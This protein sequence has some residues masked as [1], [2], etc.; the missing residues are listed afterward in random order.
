MPSCGRA[1]SYRVRTSVGMPATAAI[2]SPSSDLELCIDVGDGDRQGLGRRLH[3][4]HAA[5]ARRRG[6]RAT[7]ASSVDSSSI[8][9]S[10]RMS[11]SS[12]CS[13]NVAISCINASASRG[14]ITVLSCRFKRSRWVA[15]SAPR[16]SSSFDLGLERGDPRPDPD[17]TLLPH[18]EPL[19]LLGERR[20]QR[21]PLPQHPQLVGQRVDPLEF[22]ELSSQG[23][24]QRP[25]WQVR[26]ARNA[27]SSWSVRSSGAAPAGRAHRGNRGAD[28]L[29][30]DRRAVTAAPSTQA[31][32]SRAPWSRQG[33]AR[34]DGSRAADRGAG[35]TAGRR[36]RSDRREGR[37]GRRGRSAPASTTHSSPG[38]NNRAFGRAGAGGSRPILH[39]QAGVRR[40]HERRPDLGR[41]G[42]AL[43]PADAVGDELRNVVHRGV[44][45][46]VAHPDRR[47]QLRR[48]AREP[49]VG[50][51]VLG[52]G[53][54]ERLAARRRAG[55]CRPCPAS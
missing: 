31:S 15:I 33:S 35:A 41:V 40:V 36:V 8:A 53:L 10:S 22:D 47:R 16:F 14:A 30:D 7:S 48:P 11:R 28:P 32:W 27:R 20:P 39:R 44:G 37:S 29:D 18:T 52:A 21:R 54:A 17:L 9:S 3:L 49:G 51:A 46:G 26:A 43:H 6:S 25:V 50:V 23:G 45:V 13:V 24:H 5:P 2:R 34:A 1:R 19:G 4:R 38:R 12:R 42:A 55:S